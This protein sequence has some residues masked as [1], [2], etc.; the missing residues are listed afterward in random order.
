MADKIKVFALGGLDERGKNLYVV[1]VDDDI[2]VFD[3]GLSYPHKSIPGVDAII[4]NCDYLYKNKKRIKAYIISHAHDDNMGALPYVYMEAP[5]PVVTSPFT[6]RRIELYT[7]KLGL[8]VNYKFDYVLKSGEK[9]VGGENLFSQA[10]LILFLS[11]MLF[12]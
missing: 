7:K 8:K 10:L 12:L 6:A 2:F 5:A 9:K 11:H 1:E 3:C 4:P